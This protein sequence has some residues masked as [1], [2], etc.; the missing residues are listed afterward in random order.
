MQGGRRVFSTGLKEFFMLLYIHVPYC[1]A[2][3][4]YCSFFSLPLPDHQALKDWV[5]L[6]LEEIALWAGRLG[7]ASFSTLYI[8]GGT[9]SLLSLRDVERLVTALDRAFDLQPGLEWSLEANP[10]SCRD[11]DWLRGLKS[12]GVNRLSLGLQ[13]LDNRH[14][15]RLGRLHDAAQGT[16]AFDLARR[17]GFENISVDLIW[18][19]SGQRLRGWLKTLEKVMH[20]RPDHVSCYGLSL[21]PRTAL[22][23]DVASGRTALPG[24]QEQARMFLQ[25]AEMLESLGMLQY[26]ISNFS[27]AGY[28]CRHNQGYWEGADY[29]GLGPGAVSSVGGRRG[30]NPRDPDLHARLVRLGRTGDNTLEL[31]PA[32]RLKELIILSLRTARGLDLASCSR[33]SGGDVQH[34]HRL[35]I[36]ALREKG[37]IR[38]DGGRLCLTRA[39]MLVSNSILERLLALVP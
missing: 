30:E 3:C 23:E 6:L 8:G 18:G 22:A 13:S 17:A 25:G 27:R 1:R 21:E 4:A 37:L 20:L 16:R 38:M 14:L 35:L 39:G 31:T 28:A 26:E 29:L 2:K 7:R 32:E 36:Q 33:L 9:P 12:L 19:L 24:D 15:L 10:D 5:D 11:A 34:D